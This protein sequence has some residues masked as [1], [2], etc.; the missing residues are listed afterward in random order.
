MQKVYISCQDISNMVTVL[1]FGDSIAYGAFEKEQG[2]VSKL[3]DYLER[4]S[5]I[6]PSFDFVYN[7]SIPGDTSSALI[8][9]FEY[10]AYSRIDIP[11]ETVIMFALGIN[12]CAYNNEK[13]KAFVPQDEFIDNLKELITQAKKFNTQIVFLGLTPCDEAKT[14]PCLWDKSVAYSNEFIIKYNAIIK[15]VCKE[16]DVYFIDIL[17]SFSKPNFKS[18]LEDGLHPNTRGQ[19]KIFDSIRVFFSK[20][21]RCIKGKL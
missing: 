19:E 20:Y 5:E 9:R 16:Y 4:N 7:L 13:A 15:Q 1:V 12:D 14:N 8:H 11:E 21:V 6:L 17:D 2:W 18:L 10:E 3:R